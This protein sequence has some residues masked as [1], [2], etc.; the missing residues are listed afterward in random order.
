MSATKVTILRTTSGSGGELCSAPQS[1]FAEPGDRK[2]ELDDDHRADDLPDLQR[3]GGHERREGRAHRVP[4]EHVPVRLAAALRREHEVGVHQ[5][6]EVTAEYPE[7]AGKGR[8]RCRRHRQD[9]R[10]EVAS[11]RL[12]RMGTHPWERTT[13]QLQRDD[14]DDEHRA[15]EHRERRGEANWTI[16]VTRSTKPFGRSGRE[17]S[18]AGIAMTTE[19]HLVARTTISRV[20]G[21]RLRISESTLKVLSASAD[22]P[23]SPWINAVRSHNQ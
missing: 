8:E 16:V 23:K 10:F 14:L 20:I 9:R 2:E 17:I 15:D 3:S 13:V 4:C 11:G 7:Q 18:A 19:T 5:A 22:E 1:G 6:D 12:V 21:P